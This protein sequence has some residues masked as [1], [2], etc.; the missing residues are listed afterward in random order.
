MARVRLLYFAWLRDRVG[1]AEEALELPPEVADVAALLGWLR[2][3]E[4]V[5]AAL[6]GEG[7]AIRVAVNQAFA[8]PDAAIA[9][10]DE[11]ALFPPVT[12]G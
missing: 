8:R 2:G 12:G 9:D 4:P 1:R 3:R 6:A 5:L 10:G 7:R 11:V